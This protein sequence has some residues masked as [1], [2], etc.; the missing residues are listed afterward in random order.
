MTET[1]RFSLT[2][3]QLAEQIAEAVLD[4]YDPG[5]AMYR[6]PDTPEDVGAQAVLKALHEE[7]CWFCRLT[8][9]P[10]QGT[11]SERLPLLDLMEQP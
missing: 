3:L 4:A 6:H 1:P 2:T 8:D 7:S 11:V 5:G 9:V 10:G